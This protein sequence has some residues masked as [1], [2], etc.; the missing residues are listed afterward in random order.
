MSGILS[1]RENSHNLRNFQ[2]LESLHKR[3]VTFGIETISCRGPQV[4][5]LIPERIRALETFISID[6]N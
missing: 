1:T 3:T 6:L 4:Q 5:N 2:E